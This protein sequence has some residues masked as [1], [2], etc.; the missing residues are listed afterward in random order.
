MVSEVH[1]CAEVE[2]R[3]G[4]GNLWGGVDGWGYGM[5]GRGRG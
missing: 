4:I 3:P 2:L 1:I 5:V